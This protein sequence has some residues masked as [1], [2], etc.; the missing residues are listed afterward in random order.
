MESW[1]RIDLTPPP[2][3]THL[4]SDLTDWQ[5]APLPVEKIAPFELPDDAYFE[6]AFQDAEGTRRP[7]PDNDNPRQNPWWEFASNIAG[8]DY[9]ADPWVA[10]RD[11]RPRGRVL[12]MEIPSKILNQTRRV[13]VY[14]PAGMAEDSLPLI[15]FQ[16]GKAYYGW[17]RVPQVLDQ[18][19]EAGKCSPA[20]LVF[21]P[22]RERTQE[23]GFNPKYRQFLIEELIPTVE[24]RIRCDSRR[25]AWGA[26][27]GGLL[28]A[29]LA[30]ERPDLFQ[31]VVTQ[32]AAFLFS[33]ETLK[34]NP[35]VGNEFMLS[36][37]LAADPPQL[38]WHLDC[39]TLEWLLPSNQRLEQALVQKGAS[40]KL[41]TR[42]AGHNWTNWRNGL[43][44]GLRFA[45]GDGA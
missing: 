20:H 30:W 16:D 21:V 1:M 19:L 38:E 28:S 40:V 14:S 7:D 11:V 43:A 23:Y 17:G 22:P 25:I 8:P 29:Q 44:Q 13:L 35:F 45:L 36:Q 6:Y 32:S 4:L 24:A 37:V 33:P 3:A 10:D 31:K 34:A 27:L 18:L 12:R 15:L 39:G 41:V 26:S 42:A 9:R 2:W 5:R